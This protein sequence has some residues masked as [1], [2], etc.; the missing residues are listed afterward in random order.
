MKKLLP[1]VLIFVLLFSAATFGSVTV[2][3]N[4]TSGTTGECYWSLDGT[5]LTVSGN[6]DMGD[7]GHTEWGEAI[8]KVVIEDGVT[9]I[10]DKAFSWCANLTSV[11]IPDS[12]TSIGN[13]AFYQCIN[14]A[15]L[16][17][18]GSVTSI[19]D[20]AFNEANQIVIHSYKNSQAEQYAIDK[21][22]AYSVL[23]GTDEE[24]IISDKI[25]KYNWSVDKRTGVLSI[26][27]SGDLID[28]VGIDPPWYD[29]RIYITSIKLPTTIN[30]IGNFSFKG[31]YKVKTLTIPNSVTNIG[32]NAFSGCANL[33][34]INFGKGV[35]RIGNSAFS[36]C[37]NLTKI[38]LPDC[39]TSIDDAA[40]SSCINLKSVTLPN[41]ITSISNRLFDF[42]TNLTDVTIPDSVKS[43][44]AYAF[45]Y[46]TNLKEITLPYNVSKVNY[47]AFYAC[48]SLEK[49]VFFNKDCNFDLNCGLNYNHILYGFKNSPA[50]AFAEQIG[51]EY[52][53]IMTIHS[54]KFDN[55]V[56][57]K[58]ATCK[59]A[60]VKTFTCKVCKTTKTT[61]I[62]KLTKH[63]YNTKTTKATLTKNGSIVKKCAV[64][65]K[66]ASK[67]AIKYAKTFKLSTTNYT[68]NG[69]TKTPS[70][71][72]KDSAGK[73]LKKNVDYTLSYSS[74]RKGIGNYKVKIKM[75][76][77]YSGTKTLSFKIRP[78]TPKVKSAKISNGIK[79]SWNK[80]KG[81]KGY[82]VFRRK[83][84][85]GKWSGWGKIATSKNIYYKDK[86]AKK[87][88]YYQYTTRAYYKTYL[89]SY[90]KS[91][92]VKR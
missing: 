80:V 31:L 21:A 37:T 70:V 39:I 82:Y 71:T 5:V 41:G 11:T 68:Y 61:S 38:T 84:T 48:N 16:T 83:Y 18:P 25:R 60:G 44:G 32:D 9:S 78:A 35:K 52:I 62:K 40:F 34:K 1:V 10:G 23:D 77:K 67:T 57:S 20:D 26:S 17:V 85:K 86:S 54:H 12:V 69:K 87:G 8:T 15:S 55:G 24:N 72:V 56:I 90:V 29:Y 2:S 14:L 28:F 27:G 13:A 19:A 47:W 76:G 30:K 64:C 59:A 7:S 89:S 79:V 53:D 49:V 4:A 65:G 73:L 3:A 58:K 63:T 66:V 75:I 43:I 51:A 6:G 81:A 45:K 22:I 91:N 46:C 42:C 88:V 33:T 92:T 74:G 50:R 36:S